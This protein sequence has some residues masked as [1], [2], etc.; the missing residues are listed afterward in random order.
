M[1]FD[2]QVYGLGFLAILSIDRWYSRTMGGF[3][4]G[5]RM[6]GNRVL[7]VDDE[8][9]LR[10]TFPAILRMHG[11]DVRSA[12]SVAQALMEMTTRTFDILISDLNI[13]EPGDGFT[14]VSA[15]RRTQPDCINFILTGFP[16]FESALQAIQSQVDDFLI[17]PANIEELVELIQQKL[18]NRQPCQS[19]AP[20]R[21]SKLLRANVEE[22][23]ESAIC[24][25]KSDPAL[26]PVPLS[27]AERGGELHAII[28]EI[29]NQLDSL[30]PE[31]LTG[32][33]IELSRKH[34]SKRL[35]GGYRIS[36][37]VTDTVILEGVVYDM[38]RQG[39]LMLDTSNLV[40]D[41]K[42][43]NNSLDMQLQESVQ[44]FWDEASRQRSAES[45]TG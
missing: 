22:I 1:G 8:S 31:Q 41:L 24:K 26:G 38:V 2:I 28:L 37:L 34:G 11:F 35:A 42:R 17:K 43:F 21:L 15:M 36:M 19:S 14:V 3:P 40:M 39:L 9:S 6:P 10:L 29:A 18:R 5:V 27:D 23:R 30:A 16:A 4:W 13:G 25:M 7:F 44:A 33:A 12:A 45:G 32:L 20:M